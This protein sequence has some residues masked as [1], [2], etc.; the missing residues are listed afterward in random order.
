MSSPSID[1]MNF[2]Q[3]F[4]DRGILFQN[5]PSGSWW[6]KVETNSIFLYNFS[7]GISEQ[8]FWGILGTGDF[9]L[10][11]KKGGINW[12]YLNGI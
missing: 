9:P 11:K 1:K 12:I 8:E 7:G 3:N 5:H 2:G 4:R 10:H 6:L